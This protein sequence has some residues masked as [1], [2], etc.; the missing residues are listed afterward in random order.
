[1]SSFTS[2]LVAIPLP[3]GRRWRL[4]KGFTYH[5]GSKYSRDIIRVP[6]GFITDFA[7]VPRIFWSL[8]SSWGKHGKAAVVHDWLYRSGM[9]SRKKADEIFL[10]GMLVLGVNKIKA[11]IMYWAVRLFGGPAYNPPE[12][13]CPYVHTRW[14]KIMGKI[15]KYEHHG[16]RVYVDEDDKGK[17]REHCL[18][19][20]CARF[21]PGLP[22]LNCPTANLVYA[23]CLECGVVLP[24]WECA[25][26]EYKG[27]NKK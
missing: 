18:C 25:F 13:L 5:V 19:W 2:E 27:G 7:S 11:Y 12:N 26:F 16:G 8:I 4:A 6:A 22:E 1:M 23:V 3:D 24:V 14:R 9:R 10:E 15:I 20:R 17:H 21:N